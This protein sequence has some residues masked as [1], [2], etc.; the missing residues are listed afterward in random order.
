M[1]PVR[2]GSPLSARAAARGPSLLA[3]LLMAPLVAAVAAAEVRFPKPPPP[4]P[5][6]SADCAGLLGMLQSA[7]RL[8]DIPIP[9]DERLP[10]VV[11]R[12]VDSWP[13][14]RDYLRCARDAS[15][16]EQLLGCAKRWRPRLRRGPVETPPAQVQA[17]SA[18]GPSPAALCLYADARY[19]PGAVVLMPG[20]SG[21]YQCTEV[22]AGRLGWAR[23]GGD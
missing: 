12:C 21:P 11:D 2:P 5:L 19:S 8:E 16:H 1:R 23:M 15:G 17:D 10:A 14:Y 18:A 4:P 9:P 7:Q 20:V 6:T 13:R 3:L 22:G